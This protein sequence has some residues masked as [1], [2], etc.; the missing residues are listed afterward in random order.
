MSGPRATS[1]ERAYWKAIGEA[2]RR[3]EAESLP[4]ASLAEVFERMS[5]IRLRLGPLA[6]AGLPAD[7][8][9]AI[10]ENRRIRERFL[11]KGQRGA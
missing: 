8:A 7:D 3:V 2:S 6:E 4:A 5:A 9:A 11:R 1:A 10:D